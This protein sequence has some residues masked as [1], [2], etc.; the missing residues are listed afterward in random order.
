MHGQNW[1]FLLRLG[2]SEW[3][4][5]ATIGTG[6]FIENGEVVDTS[7]GS[8]TEERGDWCGSGDLSIG[9]PILLFRRDSHVWMD[10]VPLNE[11]M[12]SAF[13]HCNPAPDSEYRPFS[14]MS[15]PSFRS[16]LAL[17]LMT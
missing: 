3:P 16:S 5:Y 17:A 6:F 7:T 8:Q 12:T 15:F 9:P 14:V 4:S 13:T 2:P 11:G 1:G 10:R